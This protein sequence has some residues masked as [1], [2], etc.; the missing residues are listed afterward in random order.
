MFDEEFN[1]LSNKEQEDFARV[2]NNLM[3]KS[4]ILR[5]NY[6]RQAKMLKTNK[7]YSFIERNIELIRDYLT[8]SGW[9]IEKDSRLGVVYISNTYQDNRIRI[10]FMTSLIIYGLRYAYEI[11]KE[12]NQMTEQVYFSAASLMQILIEK[13]LIKMDKRPSATALASSYRF[14]E[15]HNI[16][17][18]IRGDFR[19]RDL[20]FY[21]LPSILF[22]IDIGAIN[23][24]F[25]EVENGNLADF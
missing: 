17:A 16:I 25:D 4:F 19:D 15:N 13:S 20:E 10:D 23:A 9:V 24:I 2:V 18:R 3:L 21:I 5:E 1:K 14:L 11:Q 7:D 6:D 12:Q 22:V 8:F